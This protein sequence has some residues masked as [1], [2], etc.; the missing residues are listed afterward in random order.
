MTEFEIIADEV[1]R[2]FGIST[3]VIQL[4]CRKKESRLPRQLCQ[5]LAKDL[6]K[7][8]LQRIADYFGNQKHCNV[9][10]SVKVIHK[11]VD[12]Y[13]SFAEIYCKLHHNIK[14]RLNGEVC[15]PI[16]ET[17]AKETYEK[18]EVYEVV[19][20]KRKQDKRSQITNNYIYNAF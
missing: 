4:K 9:K 17:G 19:K 16:R 11:D 7:A 13:C 6:T 3:S 14:T 1:A 2:Y 8:T 15:E 12:I 5:A 10:H 18:K 20:T